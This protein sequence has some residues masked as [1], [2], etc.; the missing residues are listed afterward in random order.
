MQFHIG[1]R[2]MTSTSLVGIPVETVGIVV[3]V[4]ADNYYDVHLDG[5]PT[6]CFLSGKNLDLMPST[7]TD[8]ASERRLS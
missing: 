2:V 8:A 6:P 4:C 7:D 3:L 1:D 5:F